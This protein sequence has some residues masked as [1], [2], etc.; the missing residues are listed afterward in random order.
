LVD[1]LV[2]KAL[3]TGLQGLIIRVRPGND[4]ALRCYRACGFVDLDP[5]RTAE[6]NVGQ[7]LSYLWLERVCSAPLGH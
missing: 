6:W 4:I 2:T 5:E 1:V 3:A 7:R